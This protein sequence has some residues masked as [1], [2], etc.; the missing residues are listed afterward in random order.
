VLTG[1]IGW[2]V[3]ASAHRSS[4]SAIPATAGPTPAATAAPATPGSTSSTKA[5]R[6]RGTITAET[7][8][9]WTLTTASGKTVAVS[10]GKGTKFGTKQ[11][12]AQRAQLPVGT[13]VVVTGTE[14]DGVIQAERIAAATPAPASTT[15]PT[16]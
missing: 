11:A 1:A 3:L 6:V 9:S 12:P 10:I 14:K 5:P 16:R 13:V 8:A 7:E 15:T 4:S 2:A